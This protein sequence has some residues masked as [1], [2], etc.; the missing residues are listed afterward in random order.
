MILVIRIITCEQ[1]VIAS[2]KAQKS[3]LQN[4]APSSAVRS[5]QLEDHG[6]HRV[7]FRSAKGVAPFRGAKGDYPLERMIGLWIPTSNH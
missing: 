1:L 6:S 4:F 5:Y 2:P 7:A 3:I